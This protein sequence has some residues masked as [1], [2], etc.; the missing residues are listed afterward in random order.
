MAYDKPFDHYIA[1]CL[2]YYDIADSIANQ[3]KIDFIFSL[4]FKVYFSLP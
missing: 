1:N 2:K 4:R 3:S